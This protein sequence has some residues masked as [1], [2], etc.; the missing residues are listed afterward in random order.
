VALKGKENS[1]LY[2]GWEKKNRIS[3]FRW[4]VVV[5]HDMNKL[6]YES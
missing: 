2:C 4:I 5:F 3:Q 6:Q 1:E